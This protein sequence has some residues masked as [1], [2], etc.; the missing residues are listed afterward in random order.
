MSGTGK[1]TEAVLCFCLSQ[2]LGDLFAA[3]ELSPSN[4]NS[5][6]EGL[7]GSMEGKR[8]IQL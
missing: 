3:K 1:E 6:P 2:G 8:I 5:Y 7:Y 4:R